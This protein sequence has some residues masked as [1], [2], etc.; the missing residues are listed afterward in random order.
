[1]KVT[2]G[3]KSVL[4]SYQSPKPESNTR[5]E[6]RHVVKRAVPAVNTRFRQE[7]YEKMAQLVRDSQGIVTYAMMSKHLGMSERVFARFFVEREAEAPVKRVRDKRV[8]NNGYIFVLKE[9][10]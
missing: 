10:G 7:R 2:Q 3:Y 4:S 8:R 1:M 5:G 9:Q 6:A